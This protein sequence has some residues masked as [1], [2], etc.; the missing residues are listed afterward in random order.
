MFAQSGLF[1][2]CPTPSFLC[3]GYGLL[4]SITPV[5]IL[6]VMF[7]KLLSNDL[8]S[9]KRYLKDSGEKQNLEISKREREILFDF[10]S[11]EIENIKMFGPAKGSYRKSIHSLKAKLS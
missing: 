6:L 10:V 8:L 11:R 2:V 9:S 3:C 4:T 5:Y 7:K 1:F